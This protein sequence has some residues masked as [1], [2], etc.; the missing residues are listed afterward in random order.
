MLV[1]RR[2]SSASRTR[3]SARPTSAHAADNAHAQFADPK[4][5]FVGILKLWEAYRDA[6]EDLTQSKL[7]DWCEKHF[8]G[9]L[10]MREWRE[11]HRQLQLMCEELGWTARRVATERIARPRSAIGATR[12]CIA[13]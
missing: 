3:A 1:D 5:E 6:H 12:H 10:R 11:L 7:R 8:L 2:R 4:S 9:F 13:R